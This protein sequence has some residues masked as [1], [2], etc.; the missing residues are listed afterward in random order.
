MKKC[1]I[2]CKADPLEG[3][4]FDLWQLSREGFQKYAALYGYDFREFWFDDFNEEYMPGLFHGRL[5]VWPYDP[6][7]TSPCWLKIP[8]ITASLAEYDL[9]VYLDN[10]CVILDYSKDIADEL[11]ADKWLAMADVTTAEGCGPNVGVVVTRTCAKANLFWNRA[12]EID[13]WKTAKWTDNGQVMALLG[14]TTAPPLKKI[15]ATEFTPGYHILSE[16]WNNYAHHGQ[17]CRIFHAAW[18]QSGEWKLQAMR[19]AIG[20]AG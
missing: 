10:D 11:P 2:T 19:E 12:W 16:E 13:A 7:R 14:Y 4:W 1:L 5:P 17:V 15:A 8:A 9:V 3:A 18:G 6:T 20:R